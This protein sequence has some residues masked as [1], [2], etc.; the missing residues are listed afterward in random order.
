MIFKNVQSI[1]IFSLILFQLDNKS[2]KKD[3]LSFTV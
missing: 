3:I 2:N 1:F